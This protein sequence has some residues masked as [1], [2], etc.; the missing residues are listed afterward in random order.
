LAFAAAISAVGIA[1]ALGAPAYAQVITTGSVVHTATTAIAEQTSV[2]VVFEAHARSSSTTEKIIA[3]VGVTGGSETLSEGKAYAVIRVTTTA[4]YVRG[5][6]S[7]LTTLFGLSAVQAKKLG[8]RWES[9]GPDAKQ[10]ASLRADLTLSSVTALL[11]TVKGTKLSNDTTNGAKVYVLKWTS[12]AKSSVPKLSHTLI[13]AATGASLPIEEIESSSTG[14]NATTLLS[15][16]GKTFNVPAPP[17][18]ST[19][20]SSKING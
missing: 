14:V 6:S 11:P 5:N 10:Y 12:A 19:V 16:W 1:T 4:A 3:D 18:D 8:A 2:H 7:G 17:V 13:L 9:W 15:G 20:A